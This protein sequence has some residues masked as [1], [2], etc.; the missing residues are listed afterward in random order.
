MTCGSTKVNNYKTVAVKISIH[1]HLHRPFFRDTG[2]DGSIA[3]SHSFQSHFPSLTLVDR[4]GQKVVR[5][6]RISPR[7]MH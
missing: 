4:Q 7:K 6:G 1:P 3:S 5:I 2:E